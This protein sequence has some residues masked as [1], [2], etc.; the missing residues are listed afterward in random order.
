MV[1]RSRLVIELTR[2]N[3]LGWN[4]DRRQDIPMV[5][6]RQSVRRLLPIVVS[7]LGCMTFVWHEGSSVF[8]GDCVLIRGCGRTDFQQGSADKLYRSVHDRI[9]S[10]PDHFVLYPGH[11]YTGNLVRQ[12]KPC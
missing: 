5:S 6:E 3:A 2:V 8:T 1:P 9:F 7:L 4:A 11:D 10:L 12:R